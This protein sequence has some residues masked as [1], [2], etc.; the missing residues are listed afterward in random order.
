MKKMLVVVV[1]SLM[2]NLAHGEK[3]KVG[4]Y[5]WEPQGK[6][7][8]KVFKEAGVEPVVYVSQLLVSYNDSDMDDDIA[9]T[10]LEKYGSEFVEDVLEYNSRG[11]ASKI[12][13]ELYVAGKLCLEETVKTGF[14]GKTQTKQ[15]CSFSQERVEVDFVNEYGATITKTRYRVYLNI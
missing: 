1:L 12:R 4:D 13:R 5:P 8:L 2:A 11:G 3:I 7:E 14:F 10:S 6:P 9:V 15:F